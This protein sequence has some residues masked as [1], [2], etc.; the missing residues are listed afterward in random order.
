MTKI[1]A[2]ILVTGIVPIHDNSGRCL[3][4]RNEKLP[5]IADKK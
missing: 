5:L 4:P 3:L 1:D 2:E